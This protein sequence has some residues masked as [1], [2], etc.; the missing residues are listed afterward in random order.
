MIIF[1]FG[2][3]TFRSREKLYQLKAKFIREIDQTG[4]NIFILDGKTI[5]LALLNEKISPRSLLISKRLVII[6]DIFLNKNSAV[7]AEVAN[8]LKEK[9]SVLEDTIIIFWESNIFT[10]NIR[11][12]S[13]AY[14]ADASGREKI[15]NKSQNQFFSFLVKQKYTQ[16]FK[17]LSNTEAVSWAKKQVEAKGGAITY[18]AVQ[19]L[20]SLI[21]NDLWQINNEVNKLLNYKEGIEPKLT[22]GGKPTPIETEDVENLVRG[23][24][25]ENIFAL[26]DALS[27]K[28]K[29]QATELL[30]EQIEA[31]LT[32]SYLMNMII[33]QFKILLQIRQGLDSGLSSRKMISE[34]RLHPFIIQKG[35]NQVRNFNF[36]TLKNIFSH[37]IKIDYQMKTGQADSKVM[38]NLLVAKI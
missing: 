37:L 4:N 33:R 2:Q 22:R 26:T 5:T 30:E 11:G 9:N 34:L 6:E 25:D 38:L 27:N 19:T 3:D 35:I 10:K 7:L 28:N 8:L 32:E 23:N 24:F 17:Q 15:L 14:L 1:L 21:G 29:A 12:K 16:E 20:I 13:A 18:Q 31:G 36:E